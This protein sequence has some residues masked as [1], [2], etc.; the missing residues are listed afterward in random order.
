MC[1]S[2]RFMI[3]LVMAPIG[4]SALACLSIL[5]KLAVHHPR[6]DPLVGWS[7]SARLGS[8]SVCRSRTVD[9]SV[10]DIADLLD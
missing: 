3:G 10:W 9:V 2:A 1:R 6:Y 4:R 7:A 8:G 5:R